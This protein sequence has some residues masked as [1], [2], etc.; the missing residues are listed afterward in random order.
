V[1][2]SLH[3]AK[4]EVND[5]VVEH[6]RQSLDR[7]LE[8][9]QVVSAAVKDSSTAVIGVAYRLEEGRAQLVTGPGLL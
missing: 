2:T 6:V 9:S 5:M 7:L 4:T 8:S 1:L 3:E